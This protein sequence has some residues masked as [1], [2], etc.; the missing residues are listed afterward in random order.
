MKRLSSQS[1]SGAQHDLLVA[2]HTRLLS[3]AFQQKTLLMVC[4]YGKWLSCLFSTHIYH[5]FMNKY[6]TG[7]KYHKM[8]A[9]SGT[10]LILMIN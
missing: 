4:K 5:L 9:L 2:A 8:A 3:H 6:E 1:I 7:R 10:I